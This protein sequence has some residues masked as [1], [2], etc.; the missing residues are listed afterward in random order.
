MDWLPTLRAKERTHGYEWQKEGAACW[1]LNMNAAPVSRPFLSAKIV[2]VPEGDSDSIFVQLS[3]ME[4]TNAS[5]APIPV[6]R[7]E[8]FQTLPQGSSADAFADDLSQMPV[9]SAAE[10]YWYLER[11]LAA[12]ERYFYCGTDLFHLND[13]NAHGPQAEQL[14]TAAMQQAVDWLFKEELLKTD[15][16][17]PPLFVAETLKRF[18]W[19]GEQQAIFLYG[20]RQAGKTA[21][22]RQVLDT[23]RFYNQSDFTPEKVESLRTRHQSVRARVSKLEEFITEHEEA[24]IARAGSILPKR[25]TAS[26]LAD[27]DVK[28]AVADAPPP[29]RP[30]AEIHAEFNAQLERARLISELFLQVYTGDGRFANAAVLKLLLHAD[31]RCKFVSFTLSVH[32]LQTFKVT[33]KSAGNFAF[34][35]AF[36]GAWTAA[37]RAEFRVE[38]DFKL[39]SALAGPG[40]YDPQLPLFTQT[41]SQLREFLGPAK[42]NKLSRLVAAILKV[43]NMRNSI[44]ESKP[45]FN[46]VHKLLDFRSSE[47]FS[48]LMMDKSGMVL[49]TADFL[50]RAESLMEAMLCSA[51]HYVIGELNSAAAALA[52]PHLR[53]RPALH[54]VDP[55]GFYDLI[56]HVPDPNDNEKS[57][58]FPEF[59][60]NH[61]YELFLQF[62][63]NSRFANFDRFRLEGTEDHFVKI[64]F[65]DNAHVVRNLNLIVQE[66]SRSANYA[67]FTGSISRA[68]PL[69]D[70]DSMKKLSP[71]NPKSAAEELKVFTF[72]H[73]F[74]EFFNYGLNALFQ[75]N[76]YRNFKGVR[77]L[78]RE[79]AVLEDIPPVNPAYKKSRIARQA[80]EL[81]ALFASLSATSV[82]FFCCLKVAPVASEDRRR[83]ETFRQLR[84]V[85]F[86]ALVDHHR[87]AFPYKIGYRFFVEKFNVE[88]KIKQIDPTL[89]IDFQEF[90]RGVLRSAFGE[91]RDDLYIFGHSNLFIRANF[92]EMINGMLKETGARQRLLVFVERSL[93]ELLKTHVDNSDKVVRLAQTFLVNHCAS[94]RFSELVRSKEKFVQA[95]RRWM[96]RKEARAVAGGVIDQLLENFEYYNLGKVTKIQALWRGRQVRKREFPAESQRLAAKIF[97]QKAKAKATNALKL[98]DL[99]LTNRSVIDRKTN[100]LQGL[101][102]L[103]GAVRSQT[104]AM[105]VRA[106][107]HVIGRFLRNWLIRDGIRS[108]RIERF[109]Q[110]FAARRIMRFLRQCMS[111]VRTH[112]ESVA[113]EHRKQMAEQSRKTDDFARQ[114]RSACKNNA[115]PELPLAAVLPAKDEVGKTK[116]G[117]SLQVLSVNLLENDVASSQTLAAQLAANLAAAY[118]EELLKVELTDTELLLLTQKQRLIVQRLHEKKQLEMRLPVKLEKAAFYEDSFLYLEETGV[119]KGKPIAFDSPDLAALEAQMDEDGEAAERVFEF[120]K[121]NAFVTRGGDI[122]GST[123]CRKVWYRSAQFEPSEVPKVFQMKRPVAQLALGLNFL[124]LLDDT[125]VVYSVGENDYGQLGL[126]N[127]L[128]TTRIQIVRRFVEQKE[129][130][131]CIAAG[132]QHCLASTQ[133]NR[134]YGWGDNSWYQLSHKFKNYR[135][136]FIQPRELT[137]DIKPEINTRLQVYCGRQSSYVLS[138]A[139]KMLA[140]GRVSASQQVLK[141]EFK[142]VLPSVPKSVC[143][144]GLD[145]RWNDHLEIVALKVVDFR[146][147]NFDKVAFITAN[148][149][150][151]FDH[152]LR[153]QN[154][155][156]LPYSEAWAKFLPLGVLGTKIVELKNRAAVQKLEKMTEALLCIK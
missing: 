9:T 11:K 86:E 92:Y 84:M 73:S 124:L 111:K 14:Q 101:A 104:R 8:V 32:A 119:L 91:N 79:A 77:Q 40:T 26:K 95:Y 139:G 19:T 46:D 49:K 47:L 150:A 97:Q 18:I 51:V 74:A 94:N 67:D 100:Q 138:S 141:A 98:L 102:A 5:D 6:S 125:G 142:K 34:L 64:D 115:L 89:N 21:Q 24:T 50:E 58:G 147:S 153:A 88:H 2:E 113:V 27:S 87:N 146:N 43:G 130:V 148:G 103:L 151:L 135:L 99:L 72:E 110:D 12:K 69:F 56:A 13:F 25:L 131:R 106:G 15:F 20:E 128:K 156:L 48:Y 117:F 4:S 105:A 35:Y 122:A 41:M 33:T 134:V 129:I 23:V 61:Y 75:S 108:I 76:V 28:A 66:L 112:Y 30:A 55:A 127:T 120:T 59:S 85:D 137:A 22:L 3:D 133:S 68:F 81:E 152:F 70:V 38:A 107:R 65:V 36:H 52:A 39:Y 7:D 154:T 82:C 62:F 140:L 17:S 126:G 29:P 31:E 121:V 54:L 42:F 53:P 37:E 45:L 93:A 10:V 60:A 114:L 80:R 149:S 143:V 63:N 136:R 155:N 144:V 118:R 109:K 71:E 44:K 83:E 145:V 78:F 96:A 1:V 123:L 16:A 57:N 132:R 90:V 116:A